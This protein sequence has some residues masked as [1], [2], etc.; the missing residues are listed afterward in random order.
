MK[1][2]YDFGCGHGQYTR[3]LNSC[4]IQTVGFDGNPVTSCFPNCRLLDLTTSFALVPVDAVVCFDVVPEQFEVKLMMNID[5][6]VKSSGLVILLWAIPGQGG[7]GHVVSWDMLAIFEW[8]NIS[9]RC[10]L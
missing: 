2:A 1:T 7:F 9:V 6:H 10:R 5:R 8:K 3:K 4:D